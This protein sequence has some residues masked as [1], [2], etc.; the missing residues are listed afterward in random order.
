MNT[1]GVCE[2]LLKGLTGRVC[3][4]I[5]HC[6]RVGAYGF[7]K[8]PPNTRLATM[9]TNPRKKPSNK[10]V[11]TIDAQLQ[12]YVQWLGGPKVEAMSPM[13]CNRVQIASILL[14]SSNLNIN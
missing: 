8:T 13:N 4:P 12:H 5:K 1:A 11:G 14:F 3:W 10:G 7:S 9:P 2:L 6:H